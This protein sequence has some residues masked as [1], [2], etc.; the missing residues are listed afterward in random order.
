M[1]L[2]L[3]GGSINLLPPFFLLCIVLHYSCICLA[4]SGQSLSLCKKVVVCM[5]FASV[6]HI[7]STHTTYLFID[8]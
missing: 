7:Y 4:L 6:C 1:C 8:T 3:V 5:C 2:C